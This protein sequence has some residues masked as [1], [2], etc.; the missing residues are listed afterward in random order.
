MKNELSKPGP[1][2]EKKTGN[3]SQLGK[4][5]IKTDTDVGAMA[6]GENADKPPQ[7]RTS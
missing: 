2:E 4:V 6:G 5:F 7:T 1:D 3:P